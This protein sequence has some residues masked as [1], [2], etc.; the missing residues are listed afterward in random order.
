MSKSQSS[1]WLRPETLTAVG[2]AAVAAAFLI[3]T[4]ALKPISA[5]LPAAML[6]G[7][8]LLS[9]LLLTADQRAASAGDD[10]KPMTKSPKR[11]AGAFL[12]I[13]CYALA[14]DLIGFYVST[15]IAVPLIACLFGYRS[16]A[17]LAVATVIVVGAI[18]M[19]FDFGMAQ[20]FPAGRLW[21]G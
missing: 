20:E 12:L 14:T 10:A 18:Y 1:R 13:F 4:I 17:G 3:P 9:L 16:I 8:I 19:I 7:M 11:V 5:L 21:E 15:A 6:A 2:I